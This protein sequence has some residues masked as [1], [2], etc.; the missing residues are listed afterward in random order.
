MKKKKRPYT[1]SKAWQA[2]VDKITD[3]SKRAAIYSLRY[4]QN[5]SAREIARIYD[6]STARVHKI[7]SD[8]KVR[9]KPE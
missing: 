4:D 9:M 5:K 7:L 8:C 1:K 6:L 2:R 3:W